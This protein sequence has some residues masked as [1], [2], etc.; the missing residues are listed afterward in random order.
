MIWDR[1]IQGNKRYKCPESRACLEKYPDTGA[2]PAKT[3]GWGEGEHAR[4][5][6]QPV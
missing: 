5:G 6:E 2:L 1:K 3:R 4:Q